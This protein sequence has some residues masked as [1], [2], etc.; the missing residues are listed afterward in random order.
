MT[1]R[2]NKP[3]SV[4]LDASLRAI[5]RK[6]RHYRLQYKTWQVLCCLLEARP[7]TVS[8]TELIRKI[9]SGQDFTGEKG[10]NQSLW[11]I[12]HALGDNA[13]A[14]TYIETVPRAGYRW[15]GPELSR[16]SG[17]KEALS[18]A[19]PPFRPA[20]A[21]AAGGALLM[22]IA[23]GQSAMHPARSNHFVP[24][25][26]AGY[27]Y[28]SGRDIVVKRPAERT[29]ILR[30]SGNKYFSRPSY[31]TDGSKLAFRLMHKRRCEMVVLE[32]QSRRVDRF[33]TCPSDSLL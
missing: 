14:P 22:A 33:P 3:A 18:T 24:E 1:L 25:N 15:I 2:R 9:W 26:G 13:R 16:S 23:A 27:A 19:R 11:M 17:R 21:L 30:P 4:R 10:L 20:T 28:F 8:R 31:S 12:R 29:Y 5:W 32:L 6:D 7:E